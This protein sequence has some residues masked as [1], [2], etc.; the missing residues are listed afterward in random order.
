MIPVDASF[1]RRLAA[2]EGFQPAVSEKVYRLL[3]ALEYLN[4][5]RPIGS[6]LALKGGTAINLLHFEYPRLSEDIDL[7]FAPACSL[8]EMLSARAVVIREV[9]G[10]LEQHYHVNFANAHALAQWH[11][12]YRNIDGRPDSL[13]IEVNFVQRGGPLGTEQTAFKHP[14]P[15]DPFSVLARRKEEVFAGKAVALLERHLPRDL[16]DFAQLARRVAAHPDFL[17]LPLF[18]K[19]FIYFGCVLSN[20]MRRLRP[21]VLERISE[22]EIAN[23]L[24]PL[25]RVS[26]TAVTRGDLIEAALPLL[27]RLQERTAGEETFIERFYAGRYEPELLFDGPYVEAAERSRDSAAAAWKRQ[28]IRAMIQAGRQ[29]ELG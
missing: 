2:R 12:N 27:H 26:S 6:Q 3:H 19:M 29:A 14:F 9:A 18:R 13:K 10:Y 5:R 23:N 22:A 24:V 20:G 7:D 15:K 17:A 28:H 16:F 25:L 4:G 8:E 21:E 11:A 1:I